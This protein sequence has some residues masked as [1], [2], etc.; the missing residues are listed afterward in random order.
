MRG[1]HLERH[2]VASRPVIDACECSD[3]A[4]PVVACACT[5]ISRA[6]ARATRA[7]TRGGASSNARI[8]LAVAA[9]I[10][11]ALACPQLYGR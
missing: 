9:R 10:L 2:R 6:R 1:P 3:L 8:S 11:F 5:E 7:G 4:V